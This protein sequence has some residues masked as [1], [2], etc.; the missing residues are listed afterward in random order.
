MT[1]LCS[2]GEAFGAHSEVSSWWVEG[3]AARTAGTAACRAVMQA[4]LK[5]PAWQDEVPFALG[6]CQEPTAMHTR[7]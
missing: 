5:S 6:G 1:P 2:Q 4:N 7:V 3:L